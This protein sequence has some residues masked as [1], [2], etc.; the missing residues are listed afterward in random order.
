MGT[1]LVRHATTSSCEPSSNGEKTLLKLRKPSVKFALC[2]WRLCVLSLFC[3]CLLRA[4][5]FNL[6]LLIFIIN[7]SIK[8][9]ITL[10]MCQLDLAYIYVST[11]AVIGQFSGPFFPARPAKI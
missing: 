9:S 3:C 5:S 10:L 6:S 4:F 1:R 11:R 2:F 8:Q 7:Q